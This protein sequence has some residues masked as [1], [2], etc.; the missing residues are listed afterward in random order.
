[1]IRVGGLYSLL[2]FPVKYV[3]KNVNVEVIILRIIYQSIFHLKSPLSEGPGLG[4][5]FFGPLIIKCVPNI[6][7]PL[8][9]LL[10]TKFICDF[11]FH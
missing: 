5:T 8:R 6:G 9:P 10:S 4:H 3:A 7:Q 11:L 1:M 2:E